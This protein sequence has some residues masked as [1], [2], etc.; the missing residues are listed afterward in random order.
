MSE[1]LVPRAAREEL[2]ERLRQA[3]AE[4]VDSPRRSVKEA[5]DVL[6]AAA[7]RLTA[8]LDDHRHV[9]RADWDRAGGDRTPPDTER[10]RVTLQAYREMAE[11]L[12]RV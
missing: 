10:L 5:A 4:F 8:A 2:G 6:D 7:E 12:L 11:R 3:L 1:P 9:L